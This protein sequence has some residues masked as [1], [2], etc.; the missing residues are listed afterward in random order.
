MERSAAAEIAARCRARAA[1]APREADDD[2]VRL[3][4]SHEARTARLVA[5]GARLRDRI[6]GEGR[7]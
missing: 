6:L 5:A 2:G 1:A 7:D 4:L 3:D